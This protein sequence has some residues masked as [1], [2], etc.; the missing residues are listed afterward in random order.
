[1]E[2]LRRHL[3]VVGTVVLGAFLTV[4]L[5]QPAALA[6]MVGTAQVLASQQRAAT[7][8]KV[9]AY[10]Q[11]SEV[12]RELARQGIDPQTLQSRVAAMSDQEI[13]TLAGRI[14]KLP[15]GG[16]GILGVALIVFLVLLFTDIMGYTDVFPFV[17]KTVH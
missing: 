16:D 6:G 11:R 17:K 3:R 13:Q 12:R 1:M 9:L 10:L 5:P 7:E 8:A 4:V 2:L 14:D 15:A